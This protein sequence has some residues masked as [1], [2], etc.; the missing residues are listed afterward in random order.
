MLF[1]R[2][3]LT[4]LLIVTCSAQIVLA[5]NTAELMKRL[6]VLGDSLTAGYGL[7]EEAAF[8]EL[9][10]KALHRTGHKV[11][12]INAGVISS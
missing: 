8:P 5:D 10:E 7:T 11:I 1:L 9:L 6:L 12:V 3:C 2:F 4:I